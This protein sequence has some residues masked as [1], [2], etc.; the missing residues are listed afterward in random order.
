MARAVALLRAAGIE[1]PARDAR[2][3][4]AHAM[5]LGPERLSLHVGDPLTEGQARAFGA[6]V[7]AR[8]ARK[9]VSKILGRRLFWGLEF[10]VT[11]EVLDPRPETEILV[12]EALREPFSR[13]LD[14]G[15]GSGCIL[16]SCLRDRAGASGLGADLSAAA[17]DV[18]RGNARALGL[19]ERA[20]FRAADWSAPGWAA[21]LAEESGRFDLVVS[22]PPYIAAA[23]MGGLAPE[24]R[25][26]DPALALTPG[27][28]GLDAYRA[29]TA[30]LCD[31]LAPGGRALF[32]IG[33]TQG[34]GVAALLAAAG[35]GG[36]RVLP[37]LDGR[38]RVVGGRRPG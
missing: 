30:G 5:A 4:L 25:G 37:D 8:L 2:A 31:L 19:G 7:A 17:L 33:P 27:G 29:I 22:N 28:D 15:T 9:P 6:A 26:W 34:A 23:E 10:R 11:E 16:L 20:A 35:L 14:L 21:G 13:L 18:A 38:D 12:A 32:E 36:I 1:D 3:L 24:V